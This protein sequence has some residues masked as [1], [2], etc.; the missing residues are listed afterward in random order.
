MLPAMLRFLESSTRSSTSVP[1]SRTPTRVS[2]REELTMISRWEE[3]A[4]VPRAS[5]PR[6]RARRLRRAIELEGG[7][8]DLEGGLDGG[9]RLGGD[10]RLQEAVE[11]GLR[12]HATRGAR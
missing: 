1:C 7:A 10:G 4:G 9:H 8:G 5:G 3:A 2:V 11:D 6:R 12:A